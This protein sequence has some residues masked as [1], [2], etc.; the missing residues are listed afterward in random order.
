M[1]KATD[2]MNKGDFMNKFAAIS[3]SAL[4]LLNANPALA[5]EQIRK[6]PDGLRDEQT[7]IIKTADDFIQKFAGNLVIIEKDQK[8]AEEFVWFREA[9]QNNY[10]IIVQGYEIYQT[11]SE[12]L[13]KEI[14]EAFEKQK[15][16]YQAL[17]ES[18][19]QLKKEADEKAAAETAARTPQSVPDSEKGQ[20][21]Q[22]ETGNGKPND[23]V[24][25]EAVQIRQPDL[26]E[27]ASSQPARP[28]AP[29]VSAADSQNNPSENS[30]AA[31]LE[32][33]QTQKTDSSAS[34][35]QNEQPDSTPQTGSD[36]S[37][38]AEIPGPADQPSDQE[39]QKPE[40]NDP[41][42][43][44][45]V[46]YE[47]VIPTSSLG[48]IVMKA[49]GT[50][51]SDWKN[52]DPQIYEAFVSAKK[53]TAEQLDQSVLYSQVVFSSQSEG[54]SAASASMMALRTGSG[55]LFFSFMADGETG[56][57]LIMIMN[58]ADFSISYNT[59]LITLK[60]KET[61]SAQ[62]TPAAPDSPD[63]P[64]HTENTEQADPSKLPDQ[65]SENPAKPENSEPEISEPEKSQD[66]QAPDG[67]LPALPQR[68]P[69]SAPAISPGPKA[70]MT[71]TETETRLQS[72]L[73]GQEE[74]T[75]VQ[76]MLPAQNVSDSVK[77][78]ATAAAAQKEADSV[79]SQDALQAAK[80]TE[81]SP[82]MRLNSN[83]VN[84]FISNYCSN[85]QGLIYLKA[86]S[87]NYLQIMSGYSTWR[88]LSAS[89]KQ[90]INAR[91]AQAG[92]VT[93]TALYRQAARVS[94]G[95][96][97]GTSTSQTRRPAILKTPATGT[98]QHGFTYSFLS[99][100][101]GFL[102]CFFLLRSFRKEEK[103]S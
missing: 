34:D 22:T 19:S 28:A 45:D 17:A 48:D 15:I 67:T 73:L 54:L 10:Q 64:D 88:N 83:T 61:V 81:I 70:A 7:V 84:S 66:E 42:A 29:S 85:A 35:S 12:E 52:A 37:A 50:P 62:I 18:A 68:L 98:L 89:D 77:A 20:T 90:A 3:L 79:I 65:D 4:M 16:D 5:Q 59:G 24:Q 101:S 23:A 75:S 41:A 102:A 57:A 31:P 71:E 87:A 32:N 60:V 11:L 6:N 14:S 2:P 95:L 44:G 13:K 36:Q 91:L 76:L 56:S 94:L 47:K 80:K 43:E 39:A 38:S 25:K 49:Q 8:K 103:Q 30:Q 74:N 82:A 93:Y 9:D 92:S 96:G 72:P 78:Q 63:Q 69:L 21:A 58:P 55:L 51:V 26:S 53:F 97:A 1:R 40:Q 33:P 86:W 100:L 46:L 99:V 27:E